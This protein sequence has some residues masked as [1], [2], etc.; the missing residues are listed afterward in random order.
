[1]PFPETRAGQRSRSNGA[2]CRAMP[3]WIPG[4]LNAWAI[5]ISATVARFRG[6]VRSYRSGS[7]PQIEGAKWGGILPDACFTAYV[8][9][10]VL[11]QY[12]I[13]LLAMIGI[14]SLLLFAPS[15]IR[16]VPFAKETGN[17]I[18]R[19]TWDI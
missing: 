6:N 14:S 4:I 15:E 5:Q 3:F 7:T 2:D 16:I 9:F 19:N 8:F 1:M 11:A 17:L 18:A 13:M 10:F 12:S